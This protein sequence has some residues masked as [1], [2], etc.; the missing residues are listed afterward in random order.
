MNIL[1][2]LAFLNIKKYKRYYI[3][4]IFLL[5]AVTIFFQSFM[6]IGSSYQRAKIESDVE[7]YGAWYS[8]IKVEDEQDFKEQLKLNKNVG[9]LKGMRYAF[10]YD[11]GKE[12]NGHLVGSADEDYFKLCAIY[13]KEGR[14][15]TNKKEAAIMEDYAK[16]ENL[17]IGDTLQI[18]I[19]NHSYQYQISGIVTSNQP[20]YYASIYTY[21]RSNL[22]QT[23]FYKDR[24]FI[25]DHDTGL[26][27]YM[28]ISILAVDNEY[29]LN[30]HGHD[31]NTNV[32][33][34]E[35]AQKDVFLLIGA[36]FGSSFIL[37]ILSA[38][39]SKRRTH[40]FSLLRSIGATNKQLS[41]LCFYESMLSA[42]FSVF[43]GTGL[44]LLFSYGYMQMIANQLD[45][46][47]YSVD[48]INIILIALVL[49]IMITIT[50][51]IPMIHSSHKSLTG[52]FDGDEFRYI[53]LRFTKLRYQ[54]FYLL[55]LRELHVNKKLFFA[56]V[57][58]MLIGISQLST[59]IDI[60]HVSNNNT[61][62]TSIAYDTKRKEEYYR[63]TL[64][65]E[66]LSLLDYFAKQPY[67]MI[68]IS[69]H[70]DLDTTV[71]TEDNDLYYSGTV[72][73]LDHTFSFN[74]LEL[75]G[76]LPEKKDEVIIQIA[77]PEYSSFY[78][79]KYDSYVDLSEDEYLNLTFYIENEKY[80]IVGMVIP[81]TTI[82]VYENIPDE[83]PVYYNIHDYLIYDDV[84]YMLPEAF[85][86]YTNNKDIE[87][88]VQVYLR[89]ES[90]AGHA[91]ALVYNYIHDFHKE[92]RFSIDQTNYRYEIDDET[93][94]I[95]P[96]LV[97]TLLL[98]CT[99]FCYEINKNEMVNHI[100]DYMMQR[101]NGMT[102][103]DLYKK[104]VYKA[105]YLS[106]LVMLLNI[107]WIF[108]S[109]PI[110]QINIFAIVCRYI[111]V[112]FASLIIYVLPFKEVA[113]QEIINY[114]S[115]RG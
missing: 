5:L 115:K 59:H 45:V 69:N 92:T 101:L 14:L 11:R 32:M 74:K 12:D 21:D 47:V 97:L 72:A 76:R 100:N 85:N 30:P 19:M 39:S 13:L 66:Q 49:F 98:I 28:G 10:F 84:I 80:K 3:F 17:H 60:F 37:M 114:I 2:K 58:V 105:I 51:S 27:M 62:H 18:T 16:E 99:I 102:K 104:Q 67:E 103:K 56:L 89:K 38:T 57:V 77:I 96:Y 33:H 44:S 90:Q 64:D 34:Y 1:L 15:P 87:Y 73:S 61:K 9:Y 68:R 82:N 42:F 108:I 23:W 35:L 26:E 7:R 70:Y 107:L 109:L 106:G 4:V 112:F 88:Q 24:Y 111:I 36:F 22:F 93:I 63:F 48:T 53:E 94:N 71:Y 113:N 75:I 78:N 29:S 31:F 79:I 83:R 40:E 81:K 41:I 55:A 65:E 25:K 54:R 20:E 46:L 95:S 86:S 8:A 91:A 52:T 110:E 43:I 6:I 50:L